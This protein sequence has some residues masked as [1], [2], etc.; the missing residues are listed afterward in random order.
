MQHYAIYL[1]SR[2]RAYRDM[3]HDAVQV[4]SEQQRDMRI[5][6]GIDGGEGRKSGSG[7]ADLKRGKTLAGRKLRIMSVEKGLLRETKAVQK[8]IDTLVECRVSWVRG[9][10]RGL[11]WINDVLVL[12]R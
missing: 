5:A 7:G 4:Q 1:D 2:I 8:Q 12:P 10:G 9:R 11:N 3:K 6:R